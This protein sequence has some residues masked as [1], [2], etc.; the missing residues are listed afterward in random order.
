MEKFSLMRKILGLPKVRRT[1]TYMFFAALSTLNWEVYIAYSNEE[2]Y[3]I[4]PLFE[5]GMITI[6][7][8]ATAIWLILYNSTFSNV[9]TRYFTIVAIIMRALG[10]F[11]F[12]L[13][14]VK[15]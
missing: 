14:V 6:T 4:T 3:N 9:R 15:D 10:I 5:G 2:Q 12:A 1:L 13:M 7:F 8:I 11:I